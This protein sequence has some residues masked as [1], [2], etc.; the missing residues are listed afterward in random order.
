VHPAQLEQCNGIDDN[1]D[2]IVD[3]DD[4]FNATAWYIDGDGDGF[5]DD[6]SAVVACVGPASFGPIGGD[7]NDDAAA[8]NRDADEICDDIDNNCNDLVDDAPVDGDTYFSDV[9]G[10]TYG[11]FD[12]PT[13]ACMLGAGVSVDGTDCD[14]YDAA[15]SP[16]ADEV[17]GNGI[18]DDCNGGIDDE[19][20]I[21]HCGPVLTSE[22][23]AAGWIHR[24]TCLVDVRT[25]VIVEEGAQVVFAGPDAEIRVGDTAPGRLLVPGTTVGSIEFGA[26]DAIGSGGMYFGAQDT[27]SVLS[28]FTITGSDPDRPAIESDAEWL[29]LSSCAIEDG[30]G[31]AVITH[32]GSALSMH[33]CTVTGMLG[34]A[35]VAGGELAALTDT[36]ISSNLG[37]PLS[38]GV[39]DLGN[40]GGTSLTGNWVDLI[41]V[42]GGTVA[43]D[44]TWP[45]LGLPYEVAAESMWPA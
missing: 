3:S 7:C 8:I 29:D 37:R 12:N 18:D 36:T 19:C 14:D 26:E 5:G 9:D 13:T 6:D 30:F 11:D 38:L 4:S 23:W 40:L 15:V 28:G 45:N 31:D 42:R 16:I 27:G 39:E 32:D 24:V 34:H 43:S 1:C 2:G 41:A 21:D 35:V 44:M 20:A 22:L 10:D 17:C 25:T 33:D